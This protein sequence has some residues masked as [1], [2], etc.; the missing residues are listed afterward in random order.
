MSSNI[1]QREESIHKTDC[2]PS[3]E[4]AYGLMLVIGQCLILL[5]RENRLIYS[6]WNEQALS[7]FASS[8]KVQTVAFG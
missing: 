5:F 1:D 6:G 4:R 8:L 2:A 3:R 7:Q